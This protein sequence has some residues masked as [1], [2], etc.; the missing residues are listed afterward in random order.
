MTETT[1]PPDL[2]P[3]PQLRRERW[4][5]LCGPWGFAFDDENCGLVERWFEQ[6]EPF[7]REIVVPFPSESKLSGIHDTGFHPVVWYR[8]EIHVDEANRQN[9]LLLHFGAVDYKATVW[10]NGRMAVEHTGGQT[11]FSAD[12]SPLLVPGETQVVIVRAED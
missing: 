6:P 11:A 1:S 12:I 2:H 7:D 10:V 5:D 9:R 4:S 8:R 3:R